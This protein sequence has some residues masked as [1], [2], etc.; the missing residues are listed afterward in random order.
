MSDD[1]QQIPPTEIP[2]GQPSRQSSLEAQRTRGGCL[3]TILVLL[4]I[5]SLRSMY[6][7]FNYLVHPVTPFDRSIF[8]FINLVLIA[9]N[10][11]SFYG[12]WIWKKWGVKL[13]VTSY[14]TYILLSIIVEITLHIYDTLFQG[15]FLVVG[16][17]IVTIGL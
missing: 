1:N 4:A 10:L 6:S 7:I 13:F 16:I 14:I 2:P 8:S 17:I 15:R 11:V 12:I 9:V 5:F 3:T